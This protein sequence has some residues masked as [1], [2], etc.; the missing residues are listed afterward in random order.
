MNSINIL[1]ISVRDILNWNIRFFPTPW[2]FPLC[3]ASWEKKIDILFQYQY[4]HP[5]I[6]SIWGG[7]YRLRM[8][9]GG[10]AYCYTCRADEFSTFPLHSLSR[11]TSQV[12]GNDGLRFIHSLLPSLTHVQLIHGMWWMIP[13]KGPLGSSYLI[14]RTVGQ[15]F[16]NFIRTE[17]FSQGSFEKLGEGANNVSLMNQA[18]ICRFH[19]TSWFDLREKLSEIF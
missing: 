11:L 16:G 9:T 2:K 17:L 18:Y 19:I 7:R 6:F 12:D 14:W 4:N 3:S 13:G 10:T 15:L 1:R 5:L 8:W